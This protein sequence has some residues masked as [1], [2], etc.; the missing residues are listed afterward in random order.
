MNTND[1]ESVRNRIKEALVESV[2]VVC[3]SA[4]AGNLKRTAWWNE[5][6]CCHIIFS[7]LFRAWP[8]L[9]PCDSSRRSGNTNSSSNFCGGR[10]PNINLD[11]LKP[12]AECGSWLMQSSIMIWGICSLK[13]GT[14]NLH[15]HQNSPDQLQHHHKGKAPLLFLV[16]HQD[17]VM[18]HPPEEECHHPLFQEQIVWVVLSSAQ[19]EFLRVPQ[20]VHLLLL[21]ECQT[22]FHL[23]LPFMKLSILTSGEQMKLN[24]EVGGTICQAKLSGDMMVSFPAGI[25]TVLTNN[26]NPARLIFRI[27]NV[28]H[29]ENVTPNKQL[30][31]LDHSQ[32]N[33][34]SSVFEFSM[35]ALTALLRRQSEQNPSASYFNVDILKY[36]IKSKVGAGS[37]PFQLVAYWKCEQSHTDLKVDYKYN[38]HA[39]ASPSPLLNLTLAV[40]VDGGFISMQSKPTAQ[41]SVNLHKIQDSKYTLGAYPHHYTDP[42]VTL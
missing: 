10:C 36:R 11:V 8:S 4:V 30:V 33:A 29:I 7:S 20:E 18:V 17:V 15:Y 2:K 5:Q 13:W 1:I 38:S 41:W 26:P 9:A 19:L 34:E 12:V 28:Q 37:C 16:H 42:V 32:S 39:M 22:R 31:S 21:L 25:V 14:F 24:L 23:Q 40:P 3:G 6:I 35:G 27:R